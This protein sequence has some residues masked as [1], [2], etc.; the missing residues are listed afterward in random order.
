[1]I[2]H[3]YKKITKYLK[4]KKG[5]FISTGVKVVIAVVVGAIMLGTTT[6]VVK[7]VVA[8]SAQAKVESMFNADN[9]S[10]GGS[11]GGTTPTT[12]DDDPTVQNDTIP[13]GGTYKIN[14]GA[15][16]V[17][18]G[19]VAFPTPSEGDVYEYGDYSYTYA[20][21]CTGMASETYG[22][23]WSL[24]VLDKSKAAYQ[25]ILSSVAGK[26]VVSMLLAFESCT[27]MEHSPEIPST[28]KGLSYAYV[29]CSSMKECPDIP[30]SV[31]DLNTTFMDC[32]KI[33]ATPLIP[34]AIT[35]L[36]STFSGCDK[37]TKITN[38]PS[39]L[40]LMERSFEGCS[41][42]TQVN[43][44]IPE[45]VEV[46][47]A[48]FRNCTS[49]TKVPAIPE[50]VHVIMALFSG[51]TS[52]KEVTINSKTIDNFEYCFAESAIETVN[53]TCPVNDKIYSDSASWETFPG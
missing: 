24:S 45:S 23:G 8:P 28:V 53:G 11:S 2:M 9:E 14:G 49:L 36:P 7:D 48:T 42:L 32:K 22:E 1:M 41:A 25:T 33:T 19:S 39:S 50:N 13:V 10:G 38:L 46:M 35:S 20:N 17:G 29:G 16:L 31:I 37:L 30:S 18:D 5:I 52:L 51:C 21:N 15:T 40:T 6:F 27:S 34:D 12:P 47:H 43:M 3:F 26:P 44:N 4:S